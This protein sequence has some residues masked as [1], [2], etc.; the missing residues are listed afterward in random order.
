VHAL[1]G[2][3]ELAGDRSHHLSVRGRIRRAVW[4][5]FAAA[6][7]PAVAHASPIS[8]ADLAAL[9]RDV[10]DQAQCGRLVEARKLRALPGIA[11]RNGD[12]LRVTLVPFGLSVFH[13]TINF[14]GARTYAVWD[15]LEHFD[16][17]VL[18]TTVGERTGFLLVQR[19]SGEEYRVPS[20]PVI[21]PDERHFATA[22][23]CERECDNEVAIWRI[24]RQSVRKEATWVPLAPWSDV[25]VTWRGPDA[26]AI[27]YS[28]RDEPR[29]QTIERRLDDPSWKKVRAK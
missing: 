22:D 21:A 24:D 8:A 26:I 20:D 19:R 17:L 2:R 18:F 7:L 29:L 16:T 1:L 3:A 5:A 11:E 27:E 12:E 15:Y 23:F 28:Q 6:L 9:C 13:D 25:S 10:E 4:C 14:R